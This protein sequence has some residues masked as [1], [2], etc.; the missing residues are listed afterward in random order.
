VNAIQVVDYYK[1]SN[2][3]RIKFQADVLV[4]LTT[5]SAGAEISLFDLTDDDL[6]TLAEAANKVRDERRAANGTE[7]VDAMLG[8]A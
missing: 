1:S 7:V 4:S 8:G 5:F 2:S 6:T 3:L